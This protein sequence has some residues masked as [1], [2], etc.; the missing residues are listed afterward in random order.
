MVVLMKAG[1]G[2]PSIEWQGTGFEEFKADFED[3]V[4]G[5]F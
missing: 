2:G 5:L 3:M 1:N 4:N